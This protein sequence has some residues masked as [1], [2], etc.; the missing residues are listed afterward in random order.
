MRYRLAAIPK[1]AIIVF[2]GLFVSGEQLSHRDYL[3]TALCCLLWVNLYALNEAIDCLAEENKSGG[4]W[5]IPL[6]L[7]L[8]ALCIAGGFLIGG[9]QAGVLFFLMA[10]SQIAYCWP[11]LRTKRFVWAGP[12]QSGL[13]NPTLRFLL[14]L[15]LGLNP[16]TSPKIVLSCFVLLI[17][18]HL[19]GAIKTRV[20]QTSRDRKLGYQ[21]LSVAFVMRYIEPLQFITPVCAGGLVFLTCGTQGMISLPV[22]A[23]VTVTFIVT[24][25]ILTIWAIND[26]YDRAR[27]QLGRLLLQNYSGSLTQ[28]ELK[29]GA[30]IANLEADAGV[31]S[32]EL[33]RNLWHFKIPVKLIAPGWLAIA[34]LI[35]LSLPMFPAALTPLAVASTLTICRAVTRLQ[36]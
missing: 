5:A 24:T 20:Y 34:A 13:L 7:I 23:R 36:H 26:V 17:A 30:A 15:S 12:L 33:L 11:G 35:S 19:A 29:A 2:L 22:V 9:Y 6:C 16:A 27:H 32:I 8:S 3:V 14:G 25:G 21:T 28:A 1:T 10:L 31:P 4:L 18:L